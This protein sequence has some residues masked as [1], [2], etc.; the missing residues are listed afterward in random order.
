MES[1]AS[2]NTAGVHAEIMAAMERVN[3]GH[4]SAYGEDPHT[5]SAIEVFREHFGESAK[6]FFVF[7]GTGA[8]VLG[9]RALT[10]PHEAVICAESAHINV[11]ECGAP[12]AFNG[13]KL[14]TV[15]AI[16]GKL[17]CESVAPRLQGF[18]VEHHA[19]PKV[20]AVTQCTELGTVYTPNEIR[21][22]A[23]LAHERGMYLH[24]DGARLANAAA[25][26]GVGLGALT[27][28]TGVDVLSFGGTK[29]GLMFGEAVVFL[30]PEL[31][32]GFKYLRK[33]GM[34]LASKMRFIAAQFQTLLEGDL[35]LSN[36]AHANAMAA[37]LAAEVQD[38]P[39]VK[40][41]QAVET[42]VVFAKLTPRHIEALRQS[43]YFYLWDEARS[44]V[45]WMTAWDTTEAQVHAFAER[46]RAVTSA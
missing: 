36:A 30:R 37:Q 12:E 28:D 8:N 31:A 2:D 16:D 40:I 3:Q 27:R 25:C 22:L 13:S 42:N 7:L 5:R 26:L 24:M 6:V 17:S 11:D 20:I 35:W 41:T 19:Q 43:H 38:L 32:A 29:N 10:R 44:E 9:L 15:A 46:I 1:F 34:Q 21:R 39:G 23:D 45:R 18:G 4:C 33:Q 14:L